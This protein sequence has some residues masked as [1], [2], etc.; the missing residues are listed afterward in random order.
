[1]PLATSGGEADGHR[2]PAALAAGRHRA[3]VHL[4]DRAHDR[5]AQAGARAVRC[6]PR[7]RGTARTAAPPRP[8]RRPARWSATRSRARPLDRV[9]CRPAATRRRR[10]GARR[11]R[12]GCRPGARA[13]RV[14]E[15]RRR[16][17]ATAPAAPAPSPRRAR[18]PAR[19]ALGG[20]SGTRSTAAGR[21]L[22]AGEQQQAVDEAVGADVASRTTSAAAAARRVGVRV[23]ERDVDLGAH[24]RERRA[25]LVAGVRDEPALGL[26]AAS[27]RA[28]IASKVS[29]SS[30]SSSRA[31]A[32]RCGRPAA[33]PTAAA[34]RR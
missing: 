2:Q 26:E 29:A 19:A 33:R 32:G 30:L 11:S 6:A 21:R 4:R 16:R 5:Q 22:A 24:D 13:A 1:M 17:R 3:A 8:G 34:P 9:R 10:C 25:Q 18:R 28:S 14:A 20:S 27:S 7:P 15:H 31:R 12:R 23:G